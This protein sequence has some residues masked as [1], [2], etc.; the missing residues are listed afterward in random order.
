MRVRACASGAARA[1]HQ[2]APSTTPSSGVLFVPTTWDLQSRPGWLLDRQGPRG[3][4]VVSRA[5]ILDHVASGKDQCAD[6][7]EPV[8]LT[9]DG[10]EPH[11][12]YF[13]QA[14]RA[15]SRRSGRSLRGDR[16]GRDRRVRTARRSQASADSASSC[17]H[18]NVNSGERA[19]RYGSVA[20]ASTASKAAITVVSNWVSTACASRRRATRLGM[21]SR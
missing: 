21:A 15:N 2:L 6:R 17:C 4:L 7:G 1:P 9:G 10:K 3:V 16:E 12:S 14:G 19:M 8:Y 11:G 5:E 13:R 18:S 20:I